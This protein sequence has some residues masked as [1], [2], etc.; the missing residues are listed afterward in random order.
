MVEQANLPVVSIRLLIRGIFREEGLTEA[1]IDFAIKVAQGESSL[2]Q[3]IEPHSDPAVQGGA[4]GVS[5]GIFQLRSPGLLDEFTRQGFTNW[6]N[7]IQ[8]ITFVARYIK[9]H[10]NDGFDG[11]GSWTT[12]VNLIRNGADPIPDGAG[13]AAEE[14]SIEEFFNFSLGE[15]REWLASQQNDASSAFSPTFGPGVP[16]GQAGLFPNVLP[17][18]FGAFGLLNDPLTQGMLAN[19]LDIQFEVSLQQQ[20]Q[21]LGFEEA[22]N[23]ARIAAEAA[24]T[25]F[26][27][28]MAQL[29]QQNG[30]TIEAATT[31]FD[32]QLE[33]LGL[34]QKFT[35]SERLGAQAFTEEQA[36][37]DRDLS[38]RLNRLSAETSL[39]NTIAQLQ[40]SARQQAVDLI[41]VDPQRGAIAARGVQSLGKSPAS[42]FQQNLRQFATQEL[43]TPS[44]GESSLADIEMNISSLQGVATGQPSAP[45]GAARGATKKGKS[46]KGNTGGTAIIVGEGMQGE[47]LRAGSAEV[48]IFHEDGSVEI[49]PLAGRAQGGF[50]FTPGVDRGKTRGQAPRGIARLA[51]GT[52]TQTARPTLAKEEGQP[53]PS[54][55]PPITA[56][57]EQTT[58]I[59][60]GDSLTGQPA[61]Q[62][63]EVPIEMSSFVADLFVNE[64]PTSRDALRAQELGMP[65]VARLITEFTAGT[66]TRE[67]LLA[68]IPDTLIPAGEGDFLT[69]AQAL[70]PIFE[71]LGL[72]FVPV[73]G[74][75]PSGVL[76][77]PAAGEVRAGLPRPLGEESQALFQALGTEP[78]LIREA[79]TGAFFFRN[80]AGELRKIGDAS[81][82][83]TQGFNP[84]DAIELPSSQIR[85]RVSNTQPLEQGEAFQDISPNPFLSGPIFSPLDLE[86]NVGIFLPAPKL[87]AQL[88][89]SLS[90]TEKSVI[91]SAFGTAGVNEAELAR[92][93]SFHTPGG[94]ARGSVG[95]PRRSGVLA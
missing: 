51:A 50:T 54:L 46:L 16:G 44:S 58:T 1:E 92:S 80:S 2:G 31:A 38:V 89:P 22:A 9:T 19:W 94:L 73:A 77:Q 88:W 43:P 40:E 17:D 20:F 55:P 78:T 64:N 30:W 5:Q 26:N 34:Q 14:F 63:G 79:E 32:R 7:P 71:R 11:W 72:D 42:R 28:Q 56:P 59:Q 24:T 8:E 86:E 33:V 91:I 45:L 69:E 35:T 85:G 23:N 49:V 6:R 4:S 60:V 29:A 41:G 81:D 66:I 52:P 53:P 61:L 21:E 67:E 15:V 13:S 47:G 87:L 74:R 68:G 65:E 39:A 76:G 48:A 57:P 70:F 10:R 36:E 84:R 82:L 18:G 37:K 12:A 95:A 90:E 3:N 83:V 75:T 93:I 27:R 25:A 62:P